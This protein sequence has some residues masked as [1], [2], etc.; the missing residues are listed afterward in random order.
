[1][2]GISEF[3]GIGGFEGRMDN[4]KYQKMAAVGDRTALR[5]LT[6]LETRGLMVKV[7]KLKGTRYYLNI[8]H[9]VEALEL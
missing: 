7:G 9:V 6:E 1:M 8:P 4:T 5:D 2:S 3:L